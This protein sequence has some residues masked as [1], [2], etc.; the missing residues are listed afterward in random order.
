MVREGLGDVRR[1]RERGRRSEQGREG[2]GCGAREVG[3]RSD[4]CLRRGCG[5][6]L[7]GGS[8]NTVPNWGRLACPRTLLDLTFPLPLQYTYLKENHT[9]P[10]FGY[11]WRPRFGYAWRTQNRYGRCT[12]HSKIP[13]PPT[14]KFRNL[15]IPTPLTRLAFSPSLNA[16]RAQRSRPI[17]SRPP[18]LRPAPQGQS[19]FAPRFTS[20][21]SMCHTPN[22]AFA[23]DHEHQRSREPAPQLST[24]SSTCSAHRPFASLTRPP[25]HPSLT[26]LRRT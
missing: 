18:P 13:P 6:R 11:A 25:S 20:F 9:R 21:P 5:G 10:D 24:L 26:T 23:V 16:V 4:A 2:S 3:A 17:P 22:H 15:F 12:W 14:P 19:C 7:D 8:P 1:E